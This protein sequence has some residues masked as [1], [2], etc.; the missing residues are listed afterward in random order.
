[1]AAAAASATSASPS[2]LSA[3]G[4]GSRKGGVQ[5]KRAMPISISNTIDKG[6]EEY[7]EVTHADGKVFMLALSPTCI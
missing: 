7:S 1:M 2:V 5:R 3:D 6:D 4:E